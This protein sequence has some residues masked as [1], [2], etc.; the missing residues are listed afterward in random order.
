MT[1]GISVDTNNKADGRNFSN[2]III[3]FYLILCPPLGLL[4]AWADRNRY[5]RGEN[6]E[7]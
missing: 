1:P 2:S 4:L 3:L 6:N 7:R 5:K